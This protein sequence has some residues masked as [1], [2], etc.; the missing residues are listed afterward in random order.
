M[1]T[2]FL[3]T[4]K[5]GQLGTWLVR[6]LTADADSVLV[7]AT[8]R[9]DLDLANPPTMKKVFEGLAG[10]P[11]DVLVNA[12]AFT[13]VDR[14]ESEEELAL[15]VNAESPRKLA[16]ACREAGVRMVHVSTDFVFDGRGRKPYD[17]KAAARPQTAY[18]RTKLA[19]ERLVFDEHPDALV[20]R[21]SWVFGPGRNFVRTMIEQAEKRRSG[22]IS[23]PLRV[24]DDQQ[25]RP[26]YA[27][28]LA[29]AILDLVAEQARGII[30]VCNDGVASWWGLARAALD[31]GGYR[32][33]EIEPIRASAYERPAPVPMYTV[34][35]CPVAAALGV[36]LRHW[37]EAVADYVTSPDSPVPGVA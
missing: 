18:G 29:Q 4:G 1:P 28:D 15:R 24:V 31:A 37:R 35:D 6:R 14:C 11:P 36:S 20:V 25:G 23:S 22:A 30:H 34:M 13:A 9:E 21:A 27:A 12:A 17:E 26:T 32:E 19:G 33:V 2:R 16:R 8:G 3:V 7:R 5:T 10:G